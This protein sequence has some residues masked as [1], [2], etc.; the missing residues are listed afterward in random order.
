MQARRRFVAR[1]CASQIHA[2]VAP[3][4][5]PERT[6]SQAVLGRSKER[7]HLRSSDP[8][9]RSTH[10]GCFRRSSCNRRVSVDSC[11]RDR[12]RTLRSS[13]QNRCHIQHLVGNYSSFRLACVLH[14]HR[15]EPDPTPRGVA[16]S[17]RHQQFRSATLSAVAQR[18]RIVE[19][20]GAPMSPSTT[21]SALRDSHASRM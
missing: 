18:L 6:P 14:L 10:Q 9:S 7:C 1:Q 21:M 13:N 20:S 17:Q 19:R 12:P 8:S 3:R 2:R 5:A 11:C 16:T 4:R 15:S